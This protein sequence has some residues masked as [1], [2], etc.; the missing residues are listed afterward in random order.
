MCWYRWLSH[1]TRPQSR[2]QKVSLA[3]HNRRWHPQG[4]YPYLYWSILYHPNFA[5][6]GLATL[7]GQPSKENVLENAVCQKS[8]SIKM[9]LE[10]PTG[11]NFPT[12]STN[13]TTFQQLCF[14]DLD[15]T[16][17]SSQQ[18]LPL[19][20]MP[21]FQLKDVIRQEDLG[22]WFSRLDRCWI[23]RLAKFP[24][25][26]WW[27]P[28]LTKHQFHHVSSNPNVVGLIHWA[29]WK[30]KKKGLGSLLGKKNWLIQSHGCFLL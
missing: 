6:L 30:T 1:N 17:H 9:R 21:F 22:I 8:R 2:H 28:Y 25:C 12:T 4:V 26:F 18:D 14:L 3:S 23:V 16:C 10:N 19:K 13:S 27:W 11:S 20:K 15:K 29:K 7:E 24:S 5:N